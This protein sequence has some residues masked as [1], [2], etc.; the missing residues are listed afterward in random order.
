MPFQLRTTILVCVVATGLIPGQLRAQLHLM[1]AQQLLTALLANPND[2]NEYG[3]D[4]SAAQNGTSAHIDWAGTPRTAISECSTFLTLLMDH[5][6]GYSSTV[7][8]TKTGSASPTAAVYHDDILAG[9]AFTPLEGPGALLPGDTI[10]VKYPAGQESTGHVMTVVSVGPWQPRSSST[11]TFLQG[12]GYPEILGYYDV[13]VID[14]SA[15]FH[16]PTDT[17]ATKPGGIGQGV[18]RFYVGVSF[19]FTG[20]TWSTVNSSAYYSPAT[21]GRLTAFGRWIP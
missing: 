6:Y 3:T 2:V 12:G 5:T 9:K 21:S 8:K 13:T 17:R 16:G 20:Y 10:A 15:S 19:T 11:Q 18:A 4:Y 14:S 7:F 1:Q